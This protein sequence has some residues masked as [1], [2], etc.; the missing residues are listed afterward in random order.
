[1]VRG[2]EISKGL[3]KGEEW[4]EMR[5]TLLIDASGVELK[6]LPSTGGLNFE[7]TFA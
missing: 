1:M 6:R 5:L 2:S 7:D 3:F 4:F